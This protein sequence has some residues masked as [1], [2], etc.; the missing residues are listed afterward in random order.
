[1]HLEDQGSKNHI[2]EGFTMTDADIAYQAAVYAKRT[3]MAGFTTVR[4]LG[5]A[6]VNIS[7]RKAVAQGLG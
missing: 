5:G 1:M 4:D 7:L 3:L 6:G 2:I